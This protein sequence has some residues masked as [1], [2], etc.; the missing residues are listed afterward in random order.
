MVR[1]SPS[2]RET[3]GD[4]GTGVDLETEVADLRVD[5]AGRARRVETA[6]DS[7]PP[8]CFPVSTETATG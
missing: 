8:R 4:F 3:A 5:L 1:W 6:G 2:L 7:I